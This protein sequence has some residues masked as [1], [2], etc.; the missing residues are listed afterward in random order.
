MLHVAVLAAVAFS[1]GAIVAYAVAKWRENTLGAI[2]D[3]RLR[4]EVE[5][6]RREATVDAAELH[7]KAEAE[8]S[9]ATRLKTAAEAEARPAISAAADEPAATKGEDDQDDEQE[10]ERHDN[11]Q[12]RSGALE[13]LELTAPLQCI[14]L[15]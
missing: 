11:H 5:L 15:R 4:S 14:A 3:A 13:I 8:K 6:A 9:E 7:A 2:R 10:G 12:A 1:S